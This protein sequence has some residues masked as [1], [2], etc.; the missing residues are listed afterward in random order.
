MNLFTTSIILEPNQLNQSSAASVHTQFYTI[1]AN[2]KIGGSQCRS[3]HSLFSEM[4]SFLDLHCYTQPTRH[5]TYER[6][7]RWWPCANILLSFMEHKHVIP[8]WFTSGCKREK[9][10]GIGITS[11]QGKEKRNFVFV[12]LFFL[13][14]PC[15]TW[16]Q[17]LQGNISCFFY[18]SM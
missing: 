14:L 5:Y 13:S 1:S 3:Y 16:Y 17:M 8:K 9:K 11:L 12:Y 15:L 7:S 18:S 4:S 6:Q 10:T 2:K